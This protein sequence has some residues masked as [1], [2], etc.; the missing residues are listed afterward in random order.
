MSYTA[1]QRKIL[2]CLREALPSTRKSASWLLSLMIPISLS[3]TLLQHFGILEWIAGWINPIFVHLGLPGSTAVVFLSGAMAGTYAGLAAMMSVPMTLRQATIMGIM[4]CICHALPMECSV[5][6]KTGSSFWR[7]AIIRIAM[8]F[9]CA[10][11]LNI[12]LPSMNDTFIYMGEADAKSFMDVMVTWIISQLKMSAM[13]L[14]IIYSLM[15]LQK[16]IEH[17]GLLSPLSEFLAPLMHVFGLPR[18]CAYMWLVGNVLG[19][20]YGSA[21]MVEMK[22]KGLITD[23]DANKVNYH[24]IMNHSMLEDTIVFAATGISALWIIGTRLFFAIIVVWTKIMLLKITKHK[25]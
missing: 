3:V 16:L 25:A 6:K 14:L 4:I 8:A 1:S 9:V 18:K 21:V 23:K 13:V 2:V 12:V 10:F 11:L 17:Y 20:S 24:L 22:E 15:F 19:I 5:N 7:M